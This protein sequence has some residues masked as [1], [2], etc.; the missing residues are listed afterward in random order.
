MRVRLSGWAAR[1]VGAV[2]ALSILGA[3]GCGGSDGPSAPTG[4]TVDARQRDVPLTLSTERYILEFQGFDGPQSPSLPACSPI[5]VP[6]GGKHVTTFVWFEPAG[7]EWVGRSRAPYAATIEMRLRGVASAPGTV[8]V[9][10]SVRGTVPDEYDRVWGL[11]DSVFLT[12]DSAT[13][14]GVVTPGVGST[15]LGHQVSGV[16]R[17][18]LLFHDRRGFASACT[19]VRYS[20]Q[21]RRP[22]GPDD[23]PTVPPYVDGGL[24]LQPV[25][26]GAGA[27]GGLAPSTDATSDPP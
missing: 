14:D 15:W 2:L 20:L 17:G 21:V 10:G 18:D 27:P 8:F 1:S 26:V 3:L 19:N 13:L 24:E 22:G 5:L 7:A 25:R 23:D 9:E 4:P 16:I 11:R 6:A 12:Y